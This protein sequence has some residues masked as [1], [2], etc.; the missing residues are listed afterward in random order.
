MFKKVAIFSAPRS[1]SSWVGQIFN[2]HPNVAYRYQPLF[3]YAFKD[4]LNVNSDSDEINSFFKDLYT[5]KDEF[6]LQINDASLSGKNP[7]FR[8]SQ[9]ATH[10]IFKEVRYLHLVENLLRTDPDIRIIGIVRNPMAVINSWIE[11]PKEFRKDLGWEVSKEWRS[12]SLKNQNRIEE[13]F[14]FE[15]WKESTEK[16]LQLSEDF[17]DRFYLQIYDELLNNVSQCVSKAFSFV[18]LEMSESTELF[19]VESRSKNDGETYGVYKNHKADDGWK[20]TLD[21]QIVKEIEADLKGTALQQ[22]L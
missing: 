18:G 19:M 7:V 13:Y 6:V 3:S 14:G 21:K 9:K 15:K 10:V 22:F 12:G 4:R 5:T 8:K 17:P 16:F 1:G 2:S 20:K 11:S